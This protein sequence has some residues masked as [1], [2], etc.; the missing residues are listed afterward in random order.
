MKEIIKS[1][2]DKTFLKYFLV[3]IVNTCIGCTVMF[4]FYNVFHLNYWISSASNYVVGSISSYLLN[5]RIT[6]KSTAYTGKTLL[7]F[8]I[9]IPTCYLIAYGVAKPAMLWLLAGC[10]QAVQENIAMVAGLGLFVILNYLGQ[11]FFVFRK[12]A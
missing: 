9:H 10:G 5:R 8:V 6:F 4:V 2:F 3:G 12:K 7:K 11:R 1:L